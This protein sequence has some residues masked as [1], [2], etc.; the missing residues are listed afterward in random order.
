MHEL[1]HY[2]ELLNDIPRYNDLVEQEGTMLRAIT[3]YTGD[4]PPED[5]YGA[6]N[7]QM[8]QELSTLHPDKYQ[9]HEAVNNADNYVAY[10]LSKF[11]SWRCAREFGKATSKDDNYNRVPP[12][13]PAA[14]APAPA[15]PLRPKL[16]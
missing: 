15:P 5:A 8:L 11:F 16:V 7:A 1:M 9:P 2:P 10:A 4:E 6:F 13:R 14:P 3:D 12:P